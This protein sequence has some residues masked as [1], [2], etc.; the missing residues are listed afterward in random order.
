MNTT[1]SCT[2]VYCMYLCYNKYGHSNWYCNRWSKSTLKSQPSRSVSIPVTWF[3]SS[4]Q[5]QPKQRR[6]GSREAVWETSALCSACAQTCHVPAHKCPGER[7]KEAVHIRRYTVV[8][9]K[10]S[11]A[12]KFTQMS[13]HSG[14]SVTR[15]LRSRAS[16]AMHIWGKKLCVIFHRR[17]LCIDGLS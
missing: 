11:Q 7:K 15:S 17:H 13:A 4:V 14:A 6:W 1:I 9:Q 10:R 16:S 5:C 12:S 3:P 2:T 8:S